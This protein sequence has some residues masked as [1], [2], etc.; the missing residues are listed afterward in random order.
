M[1]YLAIMAALSFAAPGFA[2]TMQIVGPAQPI[3]TSMDSRDIDRVDGRIDAMG[4]DV[5][6][7]SKE[8]QNGTAGVAAL[9]AID[10]VRGRPAIGVGAARWQGVTGWAVKGMLPL[11][12]RLHGSVGAFGAGGDVGAAG[13]LVLGF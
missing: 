4:R 2:E 9:S 3:V 6:A 7:A 5:R 13:S 1:R 8:A 11:S 12:D 10:F